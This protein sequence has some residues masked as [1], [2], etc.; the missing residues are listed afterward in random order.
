MSIISRQVPLELKIANRRY[1]FLK[2]MQIIDN[3]Y[4]KYLDVKNDELLALI[5]T[6]CSASDSLNLKNN[7]ANVFR[8]QN[9]NWNDLLHNY[10]ERSIQMLI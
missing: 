5:N 9:M 6:Y 1:N 2:R 3:I 10:F 7:S 8:L 4:C